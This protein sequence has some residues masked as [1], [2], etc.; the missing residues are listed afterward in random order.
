MAYD[1]NGDA[2][3]VREEPPLGVWIVLML[4]V[5]LSFV[6]G[7]VSCTPKQKVPST[8]DSL[9]ASLTHDGTY[10][11]GYVLIDPDTG[12]HYIV[13]DRG[14]IAPRLDKDGHLKASS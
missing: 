14:G 4:A 8:H 6:A 11:R 13:T 10:I 2:Y 7:V 3:D 5:L 12:V 9:T 1:I